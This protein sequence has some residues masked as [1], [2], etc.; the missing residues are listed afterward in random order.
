MKCWTDDSLSAQCLVYYGP[1]AKYNGT[2]VCYSFNEDSFTIYNVSDPAESLIISTTSYYGVSYSHQGWVI[3]EKN[4]T[5]LL[6]NDED[7]E[8]QSRGLSFMLFICSPRS[9]SGYAGWAED[10]KT[11]TYIWDITDLEHPV[12]TG[13]YKSPA[14][15]IDHNLYVLASPSLAPS[16]VCHSHDFLER[17]LL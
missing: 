6:L 3:D 11:V 16:I 10:Q 17:P 15:S 5:H 2:D 8:A 9:L 13:H 12:L 7:D 1:H 4:Q 14:V